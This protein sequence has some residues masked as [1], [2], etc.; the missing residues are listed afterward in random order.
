MKKLLTFKNILIVVGLL[1][2]LI[3]IIRPEKNNGVA[4]TENDIM[5]F[6]EVPDDV[7]QILQT[8]CYDCHSD[9]TNYP[10]YVNIQPVGWWLQDHVEEGKSELNFSQFMTY[11]PKRQKH[12]MEEI[13]E[14]VRE[15]EMPLNSYTIIHQETKLSE[16][17][18]KSLIAWAESMY[19]G[20][21]VIDEDK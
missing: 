3:Q 18:Q 15:H 6:T 19:N 1:L 13:I 8:S 9:H 14:M 20:I 17:Q 4:A 11:K 16:A 2:L 10:W 7:K 21:V 5:H 12:K